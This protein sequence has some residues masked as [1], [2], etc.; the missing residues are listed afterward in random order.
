MAIKVMSQNAMCWEREDER[1]FSKRRPLM[2]KAVVGHGADIIGFQEVTP[3]WEE[4]FKE[5]LKG[6][7]CILKYRGE[8]NLEGTPIYWKTDNLTAIDSGYF[9]LSETPNVESMGWDAKCLRILCW[10]LFET[11]DTKNRFAFVNT[12][13]DHRGETARIEGIK[14]V[15]KFIDEK[16]GKDMP[17]ILTGDFNALPDSETIKTARAL[18]T[19]AR[20]AAKI[21]TDEGTFHSFEGLDTTIDYVFLS[22][23]LEC[24]SFE[25]VKETEGKSVQSDHYGVLAE[26][27]I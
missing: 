27:N 17:L 19:D 1:M 15:C 14:L 3:L 6:Y 2:K 13:L 9:W 26:I 10:V 16:F 4:F 22:N 18:L 23:G 20:D 12:H 5:D 25:I 8:K 24:E 11:K 21:T 7:D